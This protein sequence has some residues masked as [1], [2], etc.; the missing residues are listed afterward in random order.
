MEREN[1]KV[2]LIEDDRSAADLYQ[3]MLKMAEKPSFEFRWV[4]NLAEAR[5]YEK[6]ETFDLVLLDLLLPDSCGFDTF[7]KVKEQAQ[8]T[9]IIILTGSDDEALAIRTVKEGAQDYIIKEQLEYRMFLRSV[10]YAIERSRIHNDLRNA[11]NDLDT[12]VKERT[13]E[14]QT[15]KEKLNRILEETID[16]LAFAL[17]KRDPYTAGHQRRVAQLSVAIA[18]YTELSENEINGLY[19]ASLVHDIGKIGV[20]VEILVKPT[21]LNENEI[22]LIHDH[23][24]I[25]YGILKD[26]EFAWPIAQIVLQHHEKING[27]GYPK[28]LS[29]DM[30]LLESKILCVADIF[31]AM[32]SHRPYRAAIGIDGALEDLLHNKGIIYEPIAVDACVELFTKKSFKFK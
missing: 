22:A 19:L 32:S 17:E 29:G 4:D 20:P 8:D 5:E 10:N 23:S 16:A 14:L 15:E 11:K 3:K 30:I 18:K 9:P 28:G 26:I 2:L 31:E 21:R 27:S 12:K 13:S 6:G 1:I 7:A 24:E 25:G